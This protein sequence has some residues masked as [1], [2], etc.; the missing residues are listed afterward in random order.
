MLQR[1]QVFLILDALFLNFVCQSGLT[2]K[3]LRKAGFPR[4]QILKALCF[5]FVENVSCFR[6]VLQPC[7]ES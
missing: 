4:E 3:A 2:V 5:Y 6:C 1:E 7:H